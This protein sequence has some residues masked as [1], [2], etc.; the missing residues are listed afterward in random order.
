MNAKSGRSGIPPC[1]SSYADWFWGSIY[2]S[3]GLCKSI[4]SYKYMVDKD[5]NPKIEEC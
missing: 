3:M 1:A 5:G 2:R 4:K